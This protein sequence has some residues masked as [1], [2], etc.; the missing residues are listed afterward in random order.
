[1]SAVATAGAMVAVNAARRAW[2]Q[3]LHALQWKVYRLQLKSQ[4][5]CQAVA[6]KQLA[7]TIIVY[8][9]CNQTKALHFLLLLVLHKAIHAGRSH[10][11]SA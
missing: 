3:H 5:K 11:V 10:R 9:R 8:H 7:M 2:L 6:L 1:M 4:N